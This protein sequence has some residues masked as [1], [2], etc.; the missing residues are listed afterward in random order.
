MRKRAKQLG[1][2]R[3][4]VLDG[5]NV[6][7]R[8]P[9]LKAHFER[10]LEAARAALVRFCQAWM[11]S[12]GDVRQFWVVFD[13]AGYGFDGSGGGANGVRVLYSETG[14]TADERIV[15]LVE[16]L[17]RYSACTVVSDDRE[18]ARQSRAL[19]AEILTVGD[20][21]RVPQA[22]GG[23]GRQRRRTSEADAQEKELPVEERRRLFDALLQ[24]WEE[25]DAVDP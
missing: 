16:E 22:R 13:G 8:E 21:C 3:I 10:G 11:A 20:F 12:R 19:G 23:S 7:H 1:G 25:A 24:V 18:V 6:L 2:D 15:A 17:R 4:L 9:S 5:Y 14:E